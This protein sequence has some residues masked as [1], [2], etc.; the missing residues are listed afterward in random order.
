LTLAEKIKMK[1]LSTLLIGLLTCFTVQAN[2]EAKSNPSKITT[3]SESW[4][5]IESAKK[6]GSGLIIEWEV[7][8]DGTLFYGESTKKSA[9]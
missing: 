9:S 2:E 3:E 4:T 8:E 5:P 6:V 7:P 1:I